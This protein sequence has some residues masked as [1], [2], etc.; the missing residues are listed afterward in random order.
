MGVTT[1]EVTSEYAMD[2]ETGKL[3]LI[4]Q[5]IN[6]KNL[7]PNADIIKLIYSKNETKDEYENLTDEQLIKEKQRLLKELKENDDDC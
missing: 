5:K 6:E 3:K 4:K 2:D 1:K 7:P